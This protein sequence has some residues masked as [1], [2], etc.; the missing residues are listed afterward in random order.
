MPMEVERLIISGQNMDPIQ[1]KAAPTTGQ[2]GSFDIL[3]D[4]LR[5]APMRLGVDF[6]ISGKTLIYDIEGSTIKNIRQADIDMYG[7]NVPDM[8]LYVAYNRE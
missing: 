7:A 3:V 1:L 4:P 2:L 8:E 5:G 6:D